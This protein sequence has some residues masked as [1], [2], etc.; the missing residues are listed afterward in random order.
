MIMM[1]HLT[2]RMKWLC[3]ACSCVWVLT[4]IY[5]C[6]L[7]CFCRATNMNE[8]S[9]RSHA[10]FIIT[11]ECSQ[12]CDSIAHCFI[13][14]FTIL[15]VSYQSDELTDEV[16]LVVLTACCLTAGGSSPLVLSLLSRDESQLLF[17]HFVSLLNLLIN[18]S[19]TQSH[20]YCAW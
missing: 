18:A 15:T 19:L 1:M 4:L 7:S 12:V 20:F 14:S 3:Q 13:Y 9:S 11:V 6:F 10:I 17:I 16:N 2:M 8:Q 5:R